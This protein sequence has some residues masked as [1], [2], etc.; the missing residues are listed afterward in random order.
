MPRREFLLGALSGILLPPL[1]RAQGIDTALPDYAP[2]IQVA[3][4]LSCSGG[5]TMQDLVAAWARKFKIFQP[6]ATVRSGRTTKLSAEGFAQ[7]LDG[8]I[9]IVTFV[10]EPFASELGAFVARFGYP[11]TLVNVAGGSYATRSGTH[12]LGIYVNQTNP[13]QR[14]TLTQLDAI[15]S[16]ERRRGAPAAITTWGQLG[17]GGDWARRPI[18]A[19]GMLHRRE[20]GNPPGI[21]NFLQQRV[22]RGGEFRGDIREQTDQPGETALEA[23][24]HR[25]AA[26]P[27]GIGYSGFAY[28]ASGAKTLALAES[29]RGPFYSGTPAEVVRRDYPLSRQIY[30]GFNRPPGKPVEPL[31]REFLDFVLSRQGQQVVAKDRMR[32]I[33]LTAKQAA[34]ARACVGAS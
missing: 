28:A 14:L 3:G 2:T 29:A 34:A 31:L 9:D 26:D 7:L 18:H 21:V 6:G 32:F 25:V 16:R 20:T 22:L 4:Q 5:V 24:V 13:L 15:Y 30:L 8:R 19:Y 11:P 12:A 23:I 17:L 10:R 27:L 1:L 33:P